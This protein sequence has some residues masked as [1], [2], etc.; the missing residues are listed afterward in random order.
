M[1]SWWERDTYFNNE[2]L[3]INSIEMIYYAFGSSGVLRSIVCLEVLTSTHIRVKRLI[4]VQNQHPFMVVFRKHKSKFHTKELIKLFTT[5]ISQK[6][7]NGLYQKVNYY[8][9]DIDT[10]ISGFS[11]N[12]N[13]PFSN[14]W[15]IHYQFCK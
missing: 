14:L 15:P 2:Q 8:S 13:G 1:V 4:W 10:V 9:I 5:E 11:P 3:K 7:V 12:K 6:I